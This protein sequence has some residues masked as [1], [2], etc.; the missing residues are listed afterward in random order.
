MSDNYFSKTLKFSDINYQDAQRDDH[1]DIFSNHCEI[2]NY[3]DPKINVQITVHNRK[4]DIES[5]KQNMLILD[6]QDG[7]DEYRHE[8]NKMLL[9]KAMQGQ[10]SIMREKYI[11]FGVEAESYD[12]AY[13]SLMRIETDV[14]N[15]FKALG[16]D[17]T[18]CSGQECL[19]HMNSIL[20]P[21][22]P[23]Q[24]NYDYLVG[25]GLET[26][27]FVCPYFFDFK[28]TPKMTHFE[29]GDY[30]GQ[31]LFIKTFPS[32]MSDELLKNLSDIPCNTTITVHTNSTD[33]SDSLE[34]VKSKLAYMESEKAARQQ[35]LLQ[36]MQDPDM[37][38][39]DLKRSISQ[40]NSLIS[41]MQNNNQRLFKGIVIVFTSARTEKELF[42]NVQKLMGAAR[43]LGC[44]LAPLALQQEAGLNAT[45]PFAKCDIEIRR[46][47]TTA[48]Q[49]ILIPFT[50]QELFDSG[51]MYYGLNTLSRNLIIL[52]RKA[53][54]NPAGWVL[55]TPGSGKSFATKRELLN[56]L[57]NY[58]NDEILVID[59]ESEYAIL[60]QNFGGAVIKIS[61]DTKTYF[62]PLDITLDYSGGDDD[63]SNES[64]IAFKTEFMFS[65]LDVILQKERSTGLSGAEC[66]LVDLVLRRLYE[67][68][69]SKPDSVMPTLMD[70]REEL[71]KIQEPELQAEKENL[72]K[73][74]G[75]YTTGS[76]NL[77]AH[78]TNVDV[79][80]R[81]VV[82]DIKDLGDQIKTLGMLVVLDQIWNRVTS[83]RL[84][85]R[86]TWI[87]VDEA[88]LLFN[89]QFS[90]QFLKSLWKRAR[91]YGAICTG[92]TQNVG[93]L[94][95]S[96]I[97]SKMLD[98]S[99]YIM[100]LNQSPADRMKLGKILNISQNQLGYLSNAASGSG[101]L[102]VGNAIIPFDDKFP[103]N[104]KL[105]AMLTTKLEEV[106]ELQG[107]NT[108][109]TS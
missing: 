99:E 29:F 85:G 69:F 35:K 60:A 5:F 92:V 39:Q 66:T 98:N 80:N 2:L 58:P 36:Q 26:K 17:V 87:V 105:Y 30:Y 20:N 76:F 15:R 25:S 106:M 37:I 97:A 75:L 73:I 23:L 32:V 100:M 102:C 45:L 48:A 21:D 101:L 34:M 4:I 79:N 9:D 83:N 95:D 49:A 40:T 24:F 108:A 42:E 52:D 103:T 68:Y 50:S 27:D 56:I 91:K 81:F 38:P 104:T 41:N 72:L 63:K 90:A 74:I 70:F 13:P 43:S 55:G 16:C 67:N 1:V 77:F 65:L 84:M 54:K 10:N 11:S 7:K 57:L 61:L 47:L 31:V 28:P 94:L 93:D 46:T 14:T 96:E 109:A 51:E 59:P 62:N 33:N 89:N 3:F 71:K 44:E 8:Y 86:N 82:F 6:K 53:L 107:K 19:N 64:P 88:H 78:N 18:S 22:E 12:E